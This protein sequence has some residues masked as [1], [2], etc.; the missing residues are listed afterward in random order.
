MEAWI[1]FGRGPLFRFAFCL[2]V[3]GL[4]R[5]AALS[6]HQI[7]EALARIPDRRMPL[8]QI[9]KQTA[10]WLFPFGR[11]W[12]RRPVYSTASF[13]FHVGLLVVPPF[14]LDH[15]RLWKQAVG[16][17]WPAVPR[18]I[19]DWLTLLTIG[20]GA[21]LFASR[22]LIRRHRALSCFQDFMW[23]LLLVVPYV[24]G[25]LCSHTALGPAAYRGLMVVHIWS[26]ALILILIP[27]T[28]IAHCVLA[29][30][31][32]LV[33]AVSWKFVPGAG[34][35]IAATLGY[36]DRPCWLEKSRFTEVPAIPQHHPKQEV[37]AK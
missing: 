30:L 1:E 18:D 15:V 20:T 9:V 33:T 7:V 36:S 11:L 21:G 16:F 34:D 19:A 10:G 22:V 5:A 14:L 37:A 28:K 17:A 25:Y 8:Q 23:P 6:I 31:S 13:L 32:H 27:F 12:R 3:L 2:M 29:P 24:T 26:A 35:R 4:L